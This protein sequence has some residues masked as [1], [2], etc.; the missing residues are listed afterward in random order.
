MGSEVRL[1]WR[2]VGST[3]QMTVVGFISLVTGRRRMVADKWLEEMRTGSKFYKT[4]QNYGPFHEI[5]IAFYRE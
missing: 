5:H 4:I 2:P 1:P 3:N